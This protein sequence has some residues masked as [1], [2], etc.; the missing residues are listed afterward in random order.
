[1]R[2]LG[3]LGRVLAPQCGFVGAIFAHDFGPV[4]ARLFVGLGIATTV[5][6]ARPVAA[7]ALGTTAGGPPPTIGRRAFC[8][9]G[10]VLVFF[11]HN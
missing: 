4:G 10:R 1:M 6:A 8:R 7:T 5:F 9:G 2:D 11:A 3:K